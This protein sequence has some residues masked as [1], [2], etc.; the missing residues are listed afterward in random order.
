MGKPHQVGI[1]TRRIDDDEIVGLLDRA[2]G[3][4]KGRE[5]LGF[6]FVEPHAEAAGDAIMRRDVELDARAPRPIAAIFDVMSEAFLPRIEIYGGDALAGLQQRDGDMH[7]R[8]RFAGAAFFIAKDDD[9]RRRRP[10]DI[11]LHQHDGRDPRVTHTSPG[12][13]AP[14]QDTASGLRS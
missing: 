8:R 1:V 12:C 5:F 14:G 6:N 2:D 4:G 9:M 3:L 7:G 10:A 11:S 13:N